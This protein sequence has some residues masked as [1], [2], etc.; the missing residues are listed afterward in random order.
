[1]MSWIKLHLICE[2]QTE[3]VF[4][5]DSLKPHLKAWQVSVEPIMLFT[6]RPLKATG[7]AIS[8]DRFHYYV[9]RLLKQYSA[10]Q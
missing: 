8:W 2:G 6:N 5:R 4:V 9:D 3:F 7:G 1:M 10:C